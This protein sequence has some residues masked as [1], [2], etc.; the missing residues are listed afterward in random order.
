MGG[1]P[2]Y[3]GTKAEAVRFH[4]DKHSYTGS[5]AQNGNH[6]AA[7]GIE[8]TSDA[9]HSRLHQA[10]EVHD[11]GD[12]SMWGTC[13]DAFEEF[14]GADCDGKEFVKLCKDCGLLNGRFTVTD[15]DLVFAACVVRGQRRMGFEQFKVACGKIAA[16]KACAVQA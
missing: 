3:E 16:K 11:F 15:A 9:R 1:G 2:D 7:G 8:R 10:A 13:R 4:D 5:H 14:V 6:G 12:E